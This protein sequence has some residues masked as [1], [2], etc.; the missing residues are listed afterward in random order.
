MASLVAVPMWSGG[1]T[2]GVLSVSAPVPLA[3]S[4]RDVLLARLLAN[5]ASPAIEK[6]RLERL[7]LT[8]AGTRAFNRHYLM[9]R[10]ERAIAAARRQPTCFTLLVMDL[11]HFK[12]VNDVFGH[13]VGDRVLGEFADRVREATRKVDELVRWGG[14]EFVLIMPGADLVSASAVAERVRAH[15][16]ATPFECDGHQ[17]DQTVSIGVATWDGAE[18]PH[19]LQRRADEAM[20]RAK[21]AGRNRV[22][23]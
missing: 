21:R 23:V 10:L 14:E 8:D 9:P 11:D 3:F 20:Y 15:I 4:D 19:D 7:A 18:T 1:K 17:I 2:V 16:A 13:A 5:C 6:A 12:R 22:H